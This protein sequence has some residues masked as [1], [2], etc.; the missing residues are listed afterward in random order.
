M[1]RLAGPRHLLA[2]EVDLEIG[3]ERDPRARRL[4]GGD[5]PGAPQRGGD[6]RQEL[7]DAEGL[8]HVVVRPQ[9]ERGDLVAVAAAGR[10]HDHPDRRAFA[11]LAAELEAVDLGEHEVEENDVRA[12]GLQQLQGAHAV[13]G[14]D[15]LESAHG[16]VRAHEIDDVG[17]VL[18]EE[19][20]RLGRASAIVQLVL[21]GVAVR[22][23]D[24]LGGKADG[25][26]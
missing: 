2:R 20:L 11:D 17:I 19:D 3:A 14:D 15:R 23:V 9:V 7:L 22:R 13:G 24:L 1:Q 8:G 5:R 6:P 18:D 12:F 10:D 16:E 4:R 21:L 25:E 26:A